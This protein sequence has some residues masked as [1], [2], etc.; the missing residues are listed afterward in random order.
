MVTEETLEP[1]A[2][3]PTTPRSAPIE[4]LQMVL[5]AS[6][7]PIFNILEDGTY[8][9]VNLAFSSAFGK[10]PEEV[11]GQ[12]IWDLFDAAEAEKRMTVVRKAFATGE[13]IVF[14]VRVPTPAGDRHFITS[15]KPQQD[16]QGRVASVICI[17]KEITERKRVEVEREQLIQDL[18][19]ALAKVR[20]LSGLLPICAHCKKIRDDH[21]YWTRIESYI[22]A[23]SQAEF[24]HGICPDC[25]E[26]TFPDLQS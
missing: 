7:D 19:E 17:S 14:D 26:R 21:G 20:T 3:D 2:V 9:Y 18:K 5:D 24:S 16:G 15:V 23:H 22:S 25:V 12:R 6:T 1:G 10:R 8:R 4:V 11:I 13:T